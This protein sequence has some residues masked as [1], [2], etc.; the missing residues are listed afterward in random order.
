MELCIN[1]HVSQFIISLIYGVSGASINFSSNMNQVLN[2][3]WICLESKSFL[4][5]THFPNSSNNLLVLRPAVSLF[6]CCLCNDCIISSK[7]PFSNFYNIVVT[8]VFLLWWQGQL[9]N[10]ICMLEESAHYDC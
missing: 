2:L 10:S 9:L 4:L 3:S 1:K 6:A 8:T 5:T 7:V